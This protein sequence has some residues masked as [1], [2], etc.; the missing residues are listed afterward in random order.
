M[1]RIITTDDCHVEHIIPQNQLADNPEMTLDYSNLLA[2]FPGRRPPAG[3]IPQYPYGAQKKGGTK[4]DGDNFVSPLAEDVESRFEYRPD[5]SIRTASGDG[6]AASTVHILGLDHSIL[7]DLRKAAIEEHILDA[8]LSLDEA[9]DLSRTATIRSKSSGR[10]MEFCVAIAQVAS[11]YA[12]ELRHAAG[13][14]A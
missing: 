14:A 7:I 1:Q 9:E 4:I 11:W 5:G 2:C 3:W 12:D 10:L 6:A 8:G 13:P